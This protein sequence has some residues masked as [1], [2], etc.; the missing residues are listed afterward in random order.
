[1]QS[2]LNISAMPPNILLFKVEK[3]SLYNGVVYAMRKF[4]CC[5]SCFSATANLKLTTRNK[6]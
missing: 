1:M 3:S 6:Q 4:R 2:I 5:A